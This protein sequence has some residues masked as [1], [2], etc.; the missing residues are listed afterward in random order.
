MADGDKEWQVVKCPATGSHTRVDPS[1]PMRHLWARTP[2]P[3]KALARAV[4]ITLVLL[5]SAVFMT[6]SP[7]LC[8]S[9][10]H[11]D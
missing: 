7:M 10:R 9:K 6:W 3:V 1:D 2:W 4:M 11:K 8:D 5:V